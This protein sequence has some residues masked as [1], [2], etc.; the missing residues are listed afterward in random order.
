MHAIYN[1]EWIIR[2]IT[3]FCTPCSDV[4][5]IVIMNAL[6]LD[7]NTTLIMTVTVYMF[8]LDTYSI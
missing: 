8:G 1:M 3:I 2:M 7:R 6:V 5:M 4:Y